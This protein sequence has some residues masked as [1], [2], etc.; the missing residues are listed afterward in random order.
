MKKIRIDYSKPSADI[1]KE[2]TYRVNNDAELAQAQKKAMRILLKSPARKLCLLCGQPL[3]GEEFNHRGLLFTRCHTCGHIQTKNKPPT[4]YP[5]LPSTGYEYK[6]IYPPLTETEF[7]DRKNR[8]YKPKLDWALSC[9]AE[10]GYSPTKLKELKWVEIGCGAGYFLSALDDFGVKNL[11]GLDADKKLVAYAKKRLGKDKIIYS[12]ISA[13]QI[14][15]QCPAD[16]YVAFFVYE[17]FD[18]PRAFFSSL[19]TM[20]PGTIFIFS[21]PVYG[22]SCLLENVFTNNYAR[23]LDGAV[24]TQLYSDDSINYA[25]NTAGLKM[26]AQWIFGQD[27]SD[28]MRFLLQ[29]LQRRLSPRM[30]SELREKMLL[31]DDKLQNILDK[32]LLSDQRHIV[33]VKK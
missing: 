2:E 6:K 27:A 33:A 16:I 24:H 19:Q 18:N 31:L 11:L 7:N 20:K 10:I 21:V 23:N 15:K 12:Q 32:N 13:D 9:L 8:I 5:F 26:Q 17:H 3:G 14:T 28:L 25:L 4:N 1:T 29:N 22:F 30:L